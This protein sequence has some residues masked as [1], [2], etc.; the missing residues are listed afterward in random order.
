M[1]SE[2]FLVFGV[3][4]GFIGLAI[5]VWRDWGLITMIPMALI[6]VCGSSL[7]SFRNMGNLT[8]Q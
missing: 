5:G 2:T 4:M 8:K 1:L 7:E 3:I 6:V